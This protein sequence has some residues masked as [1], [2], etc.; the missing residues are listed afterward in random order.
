M[1]EI[2]FDMNYGM[3]SVFFDGFDTFMIFFIVMFVLIVGIILAV[4]IRSV[5]QW[6]KNNNSP[7]LTVH[8]TVISKRADFRGR[9]GNN[10]MGGGYHTRYFV[11]FQVD[12]GDRME[13]EV[14]GN[15]YGVL[16]EGDNGYLTFQ[17]TRYLE[18]KRM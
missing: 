10:G 16:V 6:N 8:A 15:E 9:S 18:F 14:N 7:R 17:G 4:V 13:L 5:M 2:D 3:D 1:G 12:S 11:G